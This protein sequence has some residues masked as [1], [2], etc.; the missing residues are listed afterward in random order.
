MANKKYISK[1]LNDNPNIV[2]YEEHQELMNEKQ[3][4]SHVARA[5]NFYIW[6]IAERG[7]KLHC[8]SKKNLPSKNLK[9]KKQVK[10]E[11]KQDIKD[12]QILKSST[13]R[14]TTRIHPWAEKKWN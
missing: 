10:I 11:Q 13:E 9:C 1:I 5:L 2:L 6:L 7:S 14:M 4:K 8:E 3:N 12:T